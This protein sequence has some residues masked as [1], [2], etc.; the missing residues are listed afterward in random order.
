MVHLSL[1]SEYAVKALVRLALANGHGPTRAREIATFAGIPGKF[2]EQV[3]HDLREAGLV[4]SRRGKGGGYLLTRDASAITFAEVVAAVDGGHGGK[5]RMRAGD[6]AEP[7]VAPV[8]RAV[9]EAV[10]RVLAGATIADA[11]A[12]ATRCPMYYI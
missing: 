1:R 6:Q 9:G 2:V 10:D 4:Q 5:G 7:L 3:M 12:R 11:A 8:W